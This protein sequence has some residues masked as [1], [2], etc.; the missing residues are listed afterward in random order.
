MN[1]ERCGVVGSTNQ[2]ASYQL[3]YDIHKLLHSAEWGPSIDSSRLLQDVVWIY[4]AGHDGVRGN[5][6]AD[7]LLR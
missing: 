5:E 7:S 2:R 6:Q 4:C 1:I 3:A